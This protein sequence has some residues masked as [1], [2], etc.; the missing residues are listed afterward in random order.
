M[1]LWTPILTAG[2][3][4]AIAA[5]AANAVVD[6][7]PADSD[8]AVRSTPRPALRLTSQSS[9]KVAKRTTHVMH[10]A[11]VTLTTGAY[12]PHAYVPGGSS[13]K[14]SQA[15]MDAGERSAAGTTRESTGVSRAVG[16]NKVARTHPSNSAQYFP[17]AYVP[18]GSSAKVSQAITDAAERMGTR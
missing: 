7:I 12:N 4:L 18:G 16:Q 5:P 13:A 2:A 11:R 10:D 6:N 17:Y 15:I 3:I 9:G 1:K 14:V 8:A